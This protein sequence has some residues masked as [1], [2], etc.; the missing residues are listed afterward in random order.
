MRKLVILMG[1]F[2]LIQT[3]TNNPGITALPQSLYLKETLGLSATTIAQIGGIISVPWMIKPVWGF[4]VDTFPIFGFRTKSYLIICYSLASVVLLWLGSLEKYTGLILALGGVITSVCIA[5]SDVVADRLMVT[6]GKALNQTS[7]LQSAQWTALCLGEALMFYLGGLLAKF[8]SLSIAFTVSAFVPLLGLLATLFFF[9]EDRISKDRYSPISSIKVSIST[10]WRAIKSRHLIAVVLFIAFLKFSP[11]PPLL[12]YFRDTLG[13]SEDFVG[14]LSAVG[15]IASAIGAIVFGVFSPKVSR[16]SLLNLIIGLSALSTL[17]FMFIYN[18]ISAVLI[19]SVSSFFSMI[20]FIGVLEIS[21][22]ACPEGAEGT[23]FALLASI[24]NL[25]L[26]FGEIF[27][28]W[29]YDFKIPFALLTAISAA[30]TALCWF[31]IPIL[32]LD[33]N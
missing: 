16:Q 29:L 15:S 4:I 12:F 19:Q 27:G 24:S 21:A 2:Y 11:S 14:S 20:A 26:S 9:K 7:T 30:F 6:K 3:Y 22:R 33:K 17:C 23:S 1:L 18:P 31:L 5:T 28:G 10:L 25:T 13:F 32:K 8:T